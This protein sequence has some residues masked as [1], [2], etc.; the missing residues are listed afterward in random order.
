MR[1]TIFAVPMVGPRHHR[2]VSQEKLSTMV[3]SKSSAVLWH[4]DK[5]YRLYRKFRLENLRYFWLMCRYPDSFLRKPCGRWI[6]K[7]HE[8][9]LQGYSVLL[10]CKPSVWCCVATRLEFTVGWTHLGRRGP[11]RIPGF[12]GFVGVP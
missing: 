6:K 7:L 11:I 3:V 1:P 2:R 4:V 5:K 10:L 8:K 9:R 12:H